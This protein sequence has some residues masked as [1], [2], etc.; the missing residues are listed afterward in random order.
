MMNVLLAGGIMGLATALAHS[1]VQR[2]RQQ[3]AQIAKRFHLPPRLLE[4]A[5]TVLIAAP[6]AFVVLY[7]LTT[8][9]C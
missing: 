7:A 2:R 1:A 3:V 8:L 5:A 4:I 6:L 9:A